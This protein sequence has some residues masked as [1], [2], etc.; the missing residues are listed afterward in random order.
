MSVHPSRLPNRIHFLP[1]DA[2]NPRPEG[3]R[4]YK[5]WQCR[6]REGLALASLK[7]AVRLVDDVGPAA[8]A[9]HP[10]IA[11]TRLQRLQGIANLHGRDA[12]LRVSWVVGGSVNRRTPYGGSTAKS[13]LA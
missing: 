13:R 11:V 12:C 10:A 5:R 3:R 2:K 1:A 4:H 9:N 7:A 6:W 8:T